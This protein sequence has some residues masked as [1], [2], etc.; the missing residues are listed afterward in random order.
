MSALAWLIG[1]V[2]TAG[3]LSSGKKKELDAYQLLSKQG[4]KM[5]DD[6]WEKRQKRA[7]KKNAYDVLGIEPTA[8]AEEIKVAYKAMVKKYHPD[9][10]ESK[11]AASQFRAVKKAY[12][13][14]KDEEKKAEYDA[15]ILPRA[16]KVLL[17]GFSVQQLRLTLA[18]HM[19]IDSKT[20][21]FTQTGDV[22]INDEFSACW[23]EF[24]GFFVYY[25]PQ[26]PKNIK[27][28]DTIHEVIFYTSYS[29]YELEEMIAMSFGCMSS[30]I[31]LKYNGF[32]LSSG[33]VL[34]YGEYALCWRQI[35]EDY[36]EYYIPTVYYTPEG[37]VTEE[38]DFDD[39]DLSDEP[40]DVKEISHR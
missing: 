16:K 29:V 36:Y 15:N 23:C 27:F 3:I 25:E 39:F 17:V 31:E 9:H 21:K 22:F 18:E 2:L 28:D 8:T 24:G 7:N 1:T 12:D 37:I 13:I 4:D 6:A 10:N 35:N 19:K 33:I 34:K 40:E 30:A 26:T 11:N 32:D 5:F 20:I 14:L 38:D